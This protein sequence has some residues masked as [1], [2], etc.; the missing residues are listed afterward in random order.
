MLVTYNFSYVYSSHCCPSALSKEMNVLS[1][2]VALRSAV[3]SAKHQ[4]TTKHAFLTYQ[5]YR[6]DLSDRHVT[7]FNAIAAKPSTGMG[8]LRVINTVVTRQ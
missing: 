5:W 8:R 2:L 4:P 3:A 1:T 6:V 7:V